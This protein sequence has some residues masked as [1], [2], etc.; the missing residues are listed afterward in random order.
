[1]FGLPFDRPTRYLRDYLQA[2]RSLL[3][4]GTAAVRSGARPSR[5][6]P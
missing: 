6:A 5:D 3:D 1:M 4:T 2:L